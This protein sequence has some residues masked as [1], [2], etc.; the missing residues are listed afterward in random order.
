MTRSTIIA[1]ILSASTLFAVGCAA[2]VGTEQESAEVQS[3]EA[4]T[5]GDKAIVNEFKKAVVGLESGGGEGDPQPFE[6]ITVSLR[7][8][9][10]MNFQT[11]AV[12]V[13]KKIPNLTNPDRDSEEDGY[14]FQTGYPMSKYW[15]NEL[16]V[17][18]DLEPEQMPAERARAAKMKSLKALCDA[19]LTNMV[20]LTL[21]RTYEGGDS[22][23]T[24]EV[25]HVLIG[26]LPSGKLL[27][28]YGVDVWT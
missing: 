8:G 10:T 5:S 2:P 22:I 14:G 25:A 16:T 9:D 26:K 3:E 13:G 21:G 1:M 28:I 18:T 23:E 19:K 17:Q 27:V 12:R 15:E 20:N 11:L 4:L 7:K 24:G 6:V